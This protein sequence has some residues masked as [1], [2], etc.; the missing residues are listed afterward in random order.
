MD[1]AENA[2]REVGAAE[3]QEK[4]LSAMHEALGSISSIE[5]GLLPAITNTCHAICVQQRT[6]QKCL[7][8]EYLVTLLRHI[9]QDFPD[10]YEGDKDMG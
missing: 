10:D 1:S 5:K 3:E 8:W 4:P 7:S 6:T 2:P 9:K